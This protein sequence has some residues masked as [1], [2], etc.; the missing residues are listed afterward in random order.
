MLTFRMDETNFG[1]GDRDGVRIVTGAGLKV[2]FDEFSP[3][4]STLGLWHLHDGAC[5]GEGTGLEDASGQGHDLSNHGAESVEDGFQFVRD[6]SDYMTAAFSGQPE[7]SQITLETWV[8]G[9]AVANATNGYIG[10]WRKD[11]NNILQIGAQRAVDG[12]PNS[13]IWAYGKG[14]GTSMGYLW[15]TS[16]EVT[17]LL[18]SPNPW[19]VAVV[20]DGTSFRL[21]VNGVLRHS[22]ATGQALAAGDYTLWLGRGAG[23]GGSYISAVLDEVRLS[24]VGRYASGFN[25]HRLLASGVYASLT[26][27]AFRIQADWV[28]L[29][30][31]QAVPGGCQI[32]WE[33]RAADEQDAFGH[34]QAVWQSYGGDP[35]TLPDGRYFQ[36]R[37]TLVASANRMS[38]PTLASVEAWA[39]EAGYNLYGATGSD[40]EVLDYADPFARVGP[41]VREAQSGVLA[42]GAVHWFGIRP[43]GGSGVESPIV[44]CESR[45]E[46]DESGQQVPDRPAGVLAVEARPLAQG[47][48]HLAWRYRVGITGVVPETFRI[49]GDGGSGMIDY[50][51]PLAEVSYDETRT[52]YSAEIEGL[53]DGIEYQL[54]VRAVARDEVWDEQPA[55]F[56]AVPD[57]TAPGEVTALEAEVV[58]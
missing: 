12:G 41:S 3:D 1:E 22:T 19:H 58:L 24:G 26:F 31:E 46:L 21:F 6:E 30:S 48:I 29:I 38:S 52:G 13:Q 25:S 57:A 45:L 42:V 53:A 43:V 37:A 8:R 51:S 20:V 28:D 27:D 18:D 47:A 40:P 4:A 10:G 34:P 54:A 55:V 36:W 14:G 11:S 16:A 32:T 33:V 9:W 39:S 49:F 5:Q 7:R 56:C 2:D 44:Q 35:D 15:W 17:A 50:G 23:G